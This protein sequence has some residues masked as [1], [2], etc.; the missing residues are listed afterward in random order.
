[1][2]WL[3]SF[4]AAARLVGGYFGTKYRKITNYITHVVAHHACTD[5]STWPREDET[6]QR[7]AV[8]Q[9]T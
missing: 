1:M 6:M 5:S 8:H 4:A 3:G 7:P 2:A 9:Q